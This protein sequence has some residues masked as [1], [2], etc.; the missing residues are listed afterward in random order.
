MCNQDNRKRVGI[1]SLRVRPL[2]PTDC[3]NSFSDKSDH[4]K[5]TLHNATDLHHI[6]LA[7]RW[8]AFS[9]KSE[10]QK[11]TVHNAT[12]LQHISRAARTPG[13]LP[14]TAQ[15]SADSGYAPRT[16]A[17]RFSSQYPL[18]HPHSSQLPLTYQS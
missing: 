8:E 1:H 7:A 9:D 16:Q 11:I 17:G 13:A 12:E 5:I 10:H 18:R 2:I 15:P 3:Q 4:Q 14:A 6:S